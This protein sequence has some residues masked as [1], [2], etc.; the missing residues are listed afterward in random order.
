MLFTPADLKAAYEFLKIVAFRND[1]NLPK[2][3]SVRFVVKKLKDHGNLDFD[4]GKHTIWIDKHT[5]SWTLVLQ[6]MAHEM[7][8]LSRRDHIISNA[9]D[10]DEHDT[11][12]V[13]SARAIEIE[14]GWPRGSV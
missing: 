3:S 8:H 11:L 10:D 1:H 13:Q 7:I 5:K 4:N 6:I 12:F 14:M 2:S 9:A